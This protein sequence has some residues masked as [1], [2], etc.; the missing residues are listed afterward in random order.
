VLGLR[1]NGRFAGATR[2]LDEWLTGLEPFWAKG[3]RAMD[4]TV[5]SAIFATAAARVRKFARRGGVLEPVLPDESGLLR[6]ELQGFDYVAR[7]AC[8]APRTLDDLERVEGLLREGLARVLSSLGAEEQ[9]VFA[10]VLA[11]DADPAIE[12]ATWAKSL[13]TLRPTG[14]A[15]A[16]P[17][18]RDPFGQSAVDPQRP[19]LALLLAWSGD[20]VF[21]EAAS[22]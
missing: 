1:S 14:V 22:A 12:A 20:R 19:G 16:F 8:F 15:W 7:A 21:N 18:K 6:F 17:D 4:D 5:A 9:G 10:L 3:P 2:L 11:P 13:A